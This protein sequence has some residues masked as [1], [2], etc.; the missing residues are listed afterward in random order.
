M[1]SIHTGRTK[2]LVQTVMTPERTTATS[3]LLSKLH[4]LPLSGHDDCHGKDHTQAAPLA[5]SPF[6][7][8]GSR[9]FLEVSHEIS[10]YSE[11]ASV[12]PASGGDAAW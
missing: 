8:D 6:H 9:S 5:L 12:L 11:S 10:L 4:C 7:F 3:V 1:F 2:S